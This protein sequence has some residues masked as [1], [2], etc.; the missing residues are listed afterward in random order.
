MVAPINPLVTQGL[1]IVGAPGDV[2]SFLTPD[3]LLAYCESRLRGLDEQVKTAFVSQQ[4]AN[5][6]QRLLGEALQK[7]N[8][9]MGSDI[10]NKDNG[11]HGAL[12]LMGKLDYEARKVG[13]DTPEGK[14]LIALRDQIAGQVCHPPEPLIELMNRRPPTVGDTKADSESEA[15]TRIWNHTN[16]DGTDP[17]DMSKF[18]TKGIINDQL[19]LKDANGND[20]TVSDTLQKEQVSS[21]SESI[22]GLQSDLNSGTELGM[23]QLQSLMSQRQSSVQMVTNLIQSLGEQMKGIAGNVGK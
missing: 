19:H 7:V 16:P 2:S 14:K 3:S 10:N 18:S 12:D 1:G 15:Y 5:E 20:V 13:L 8:A 6:R 9:F 22:K 23:I 21:I 4:K 17:W 11:C